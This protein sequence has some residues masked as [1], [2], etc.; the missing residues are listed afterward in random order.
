MAN[1]LFACAFPAGVSYCDRTRE[2]NGDYLSLAFLSFHTLDLVFTGNRCPAA[3]RSEIELNAAKIQARKGQQYIV[4][5]C[6]QT[7]TLGLGA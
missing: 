2:K 5:T 4:S 1:S 6:G 7:I 3:L